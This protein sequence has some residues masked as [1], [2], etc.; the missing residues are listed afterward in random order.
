MENEEGAQMPLKAR[1]QT[2]EGGKSKDVVVETREG[3]Y[4]A[5]TN[6]SSLI[7]AFKTNSQTQPHQFRVSQTSWR[8]S[9]LDFLIQP[10]SDLHKKEEAQRGQSSLL[11]QENLFW[12]GT[13]NTHIYINISK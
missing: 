10:N 9:A 2:S 13:T 7:V 1:G 12:V 11:S 6:E 5:K 3:E 8:R 4:E